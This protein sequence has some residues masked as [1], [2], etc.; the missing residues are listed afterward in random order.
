MPSGSQF[1]QSFL[2]RHAFRVGCDA[3]WIARRVTELQ[4]LGSMALQT[5]LPL[6]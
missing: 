6:R 1:P 3:L 5:V 2:H 4:G